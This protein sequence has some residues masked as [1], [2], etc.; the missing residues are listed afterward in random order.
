[1]QVNAM[2]FGTALATVQRGDYMMTLGGWSGLLDTD[3]NAWGF[4]HTGGALNRAGYSNPQVDELLDR[5]RTVSDIRERR[6]AYE[7]VWQQVSK[8]LPIIYLWTPRNIIGL[9]RKVAGF[10]LLADGLLRLQDVS[11]AQ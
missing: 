11:P 10:T 7:G 8:D 3:S 2:E 1:V 5:A 4:L 6:A 9:N